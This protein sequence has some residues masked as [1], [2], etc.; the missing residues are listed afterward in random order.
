MAYLLGLSIQQWILDIYKIMSF[1]D[2]DKET[3]T[4]NGIVYSL[5]SAHKDHIRKHLPISIIAKLMIEK[6]D[7]YALDRW[8]YPVKRT[9]CINDIICETNMEEKVL[10]D[11]IKSGQNFSI[12]VDEVRSR[13][14]EEYNPPK[15]IS[16]DEYSRLRIKGESLIAVVDRIH[17]WSEAEVLER[18][19]VLAENNRDMLLEFKIGKKKKRAA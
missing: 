4:V 6:D 2:K 5:V 1:I 17:L 14:R 18:F 15:Y 19:R 3:I 11:L 16:L 13:G 9:I 12:L 8:V 7:V 10:K